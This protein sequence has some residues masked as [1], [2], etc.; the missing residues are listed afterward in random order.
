MDD[1]NPLKRREQ[2]KDADEWAYVIEGI[3][4]AHLSWIVTGP[5][6]AIVKNWKALLIIV[7]VI[8]AINSPRILEAIEAL[9]G[10]TK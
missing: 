9:A 6:V 4:K 2:P 5:I 8:L 3:E 10:V 7:A 1:K